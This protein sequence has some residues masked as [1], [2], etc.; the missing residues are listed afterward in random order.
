GDLAIYG[1]IIENNDIEDII[2]TLGKPNSFY[3]GTILLMDPSGAQITVSND[4]PLAD[5]YLI[6][7]PETNAQ[8]Y[9]YDP[10]E[11]Y[12]KDFDTANTGPVFN[13][14]FQMDVTG[15]G[16]FYWGGANVFVVGDYDNNV[17]DVP[18]E[19]NLKSGSRTTLLEGMSL[20]ATS[21]D[22]ILEQGAYLEPLGFD[23]KDNKNLLKVNNATLQGEI[24]FPISSIDFNNP[25]G[26]LLK[27]SSPNKINVE[28]ATIS[29]R[30]F[31]AV[32]L[33]NNG[34]MFYLFEGDYY[35][36]IEGTPQNA[37][38]TAMQNLSVQY[39][40]IVDFEAADNTPGNTNRKMVARLVSIEPAPQTKTVS[41]GYAAS[42][43]FLSHIGNWLPDYTY[44]AADLATRQSNA[45][46]SFSGV[47]FASFKAKTGSSVSVKG[48]NFVLGIAKKHQ[49]ALGSLLLGAYVEGGVSSFDVYSD[50]YTQDLREVGGGGHI[51]SLGVGLMVSETFNNS[52]RIETSFRYGKIRNDFRSK[53]YVSASGTEANYSISVPY[54]GAHVGL[55]YTWDIADFGNL[56]FS[57]KYF[58]THVRGQN[59]HIGDTDVIAYESTTSKRIRAGIR[60]T[61]TFNDN[62][63]GFIG[64]YYDR[65]YD[66]QAKA[67]VYGMDLQT[68]GL[69][70]AT[71]MFELGAIVKSS[72]NEHLSVEFGLQ[73]YTGVF[74]GI[75]GGIRLG[76]EF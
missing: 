61:K 67:K 41:E 22:F 25:D 73:G 35:D 51:R 27:I 33:L 13:R 59:I 24:M 42:L 11:V 3:F 53:N 68:V 71:G 76:Y 54:V 60:F 12:Q 62:I 23:S 10:I 20:E 34:D 18:N 74:K 15:T 55:G 21:H 5:A 57:V 47:D 58:M 14:T 19:I 9:L 4:S 52:F 64:G 26:A 75:S 48:F 38:A 70:G 31:T 44:Y 36:S 39:T 6:V 66:N 28:G 46:Q 17:H 45:W 40:F 32:E 43:A 63:S 49:N 2:D 7:Q 30:N 8:I 1:P 50:I 65:E 16:D 69:K 56:D 72:T 29:L 37:T